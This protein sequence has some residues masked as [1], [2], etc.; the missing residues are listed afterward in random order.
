MNYAVFALAFDRGGS[1]YAGGQF[2]AAGGEQIYLDHIAKWDGSQWTALGAGMNQWVWDL[3]IDGHGN[4]Y[5]GGEFS[6]A[7]TK[8]AMNVA[9]WTAA[10]GR[11]ISG[12]GTYTLYADNLP[13]TIV[14]PPGG[15]SDLTRINIQRFN[16]S[17]ANGTPAIRIGYYWQIEGLNATG[18]IASGYS[19]TLT[20]PA[21]GFTPDENARVCRYTG[22]QMMW[23]CAM[24][25]YTD[26]TITRD[27]V[28]QLSYWA[29]SRK[30]SLAYLPLVLR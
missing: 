28:T 23:D 4:L 9:R 11:V 6:A 5:A 2:W 27:D 20:L 18:E 12:P 29:V 13:V 17:H 15:E 10:D 16:K 14:I 3:A 30:V 8:G 22:S 7:G 19:V 21:P 24:T 25:L 26:N 1:L